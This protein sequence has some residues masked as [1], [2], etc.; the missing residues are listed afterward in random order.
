LQREVEKIKSIQISQTTGEGGQGIPIIVVSKE[1]LFL[2]INDSQEQFHD[3]KHFFIQRDDELTKEVI[4][5]AEL[6]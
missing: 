4:A 1:E 2:S 3:P 6:K 5:S